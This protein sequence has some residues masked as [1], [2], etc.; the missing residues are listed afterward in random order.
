M[1]YTY[2]ERH[3]EGLYRFKEGTRPS[4]FSRRNVALSFPSD[5]MTLG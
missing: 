2:R 5:R 3:G 4:D 1:D